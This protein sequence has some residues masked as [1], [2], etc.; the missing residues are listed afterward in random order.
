M[1]LAPKDESLYIEV[2]CVKDVRELDDEWGALVINEGDI[3]LALTRYNKSRK[4]HN[5]DRC[6]L[7]KCND[8][9]WPVNRSHFKT[10]DEIRDDRL[11][12]LGI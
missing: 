1:M 3:R 10:L 4:D 5:W 7:I 12:E 11:N 9:M 8:G 2:I 6:H